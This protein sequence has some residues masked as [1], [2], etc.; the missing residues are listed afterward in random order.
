[1]FKCR[2]DF[3]RVGRYATDLDA[4]IAAGKQTGERTRRVGQI[5]RHLVSAPALI[6][7]E[8]AA[9]APCKSYQRNKTKLMD[10]HVLFS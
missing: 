9:G 2:R 5:L 4:A 8:S 6:L 3:F 10:T 7:G 1:M